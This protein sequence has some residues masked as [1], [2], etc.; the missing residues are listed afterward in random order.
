MDGE[1]TSSRNRITVAASVRCV[2][3]KFCHSNFFDALIAASNKRSV[4]M[5]GKPPRSAGVPGVPPNSLLD[6]LVLDRIGPHGNGNAG[7][8]GWHE[9]G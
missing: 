4:F 3:G 2:G 9:R 1:W 8:P 5:R 7:G 6:L